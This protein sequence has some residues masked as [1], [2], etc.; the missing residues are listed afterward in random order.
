M[1]R[2]GWAA[3]VGV[4]ANPDA[5]D[6]NTAREPPMR[7]RK[8]PRGQ[9][10]KKSRSALRASCNPYRT[11]PLVGRGKH[12]QVDERSSVKELGKLAP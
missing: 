2:V 6:T 8:C 3:A 7:G 5:A 11:P 12:P 1:D 4:Q 9:A 10:V